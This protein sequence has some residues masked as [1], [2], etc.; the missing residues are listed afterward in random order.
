MSFTPHWKRVTIKS[1]TQEVI[2]NVYNFDKIRQEAF[3]VKESMP[4]KVKKESWQ[5]NKNQGQG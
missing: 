4:K 2:C 3:L 5:S 1:Q